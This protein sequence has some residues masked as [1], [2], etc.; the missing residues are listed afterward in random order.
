MIR[1]VIT[2]SETGK[3]R[4]GNQDAVL[5]CHIGAAGIFA[6]ADGMGGHYRGEIASQ[7]AVMFLRAWWNKIKD[8]ICFVPFLDIVSDLEKQIREIN[9]TIFL[10]YQ[11]MGQFGG[12]TLCVLMT[13]QDAYAVLNIGDSRA[14]RCQG[15]KCAQI[16]VDDV[17]ENQ[18]QIRETMSE[19]E[20]RNNSCYGRLIQALG[21]NRHVSISVRI[22]PLE[23]KTCF[24]L[25]S[26]GIYKFCDESWMLSN[27]KRSRSEKGIAALA[28]KIRKNVFINGAGDNFSLII[29]LTD[30]EK[31]K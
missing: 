1:K 24:L 15:R 31:Q 20:I 19:E 9:E 22:W 17:W 30:M 25:C 23:K 2:F 27:F 28:E 5:A 26:D 6:V 13:S 18:Y 3:C 4:A 29:L 21:V 12:T 10:T 8:C 7:K 11:K 16:T 14:Y